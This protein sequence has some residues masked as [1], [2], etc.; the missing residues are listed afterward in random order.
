MSVLHRWAWLAVCLLLQVSVVG[1]ASAAP[2]RDAAPPGPGA[3]EVTAPTLPQA[4]PIALPRDVPAPEG[5]QPLVVV[6]A[7]T[8]AI[9]RQTEAFFATALGEAEARRAQALLL[10]LDTPGGLLDA[11]RA[12]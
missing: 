12:I 7:V 8:G 3:E 1:R 10:V 11:T 2:P 5:R 4:A 9:T 6:V